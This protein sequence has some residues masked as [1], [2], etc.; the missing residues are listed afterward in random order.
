MIKRVLLL[1][2]G[3]IILWSCQET[4]TSYQASKKRIV[5]TTSILAD[6]VRN[7]VRDSAEVIA[8]MGYGIDPHLFK[9]TPQT[10]TALQEADIIVSNGLNL[11][12]KMTEILQKLT[13]EKKI[14]FASDGLEKSDLISVGPNTF[15]PHIW[16][17]VPLWAEACKYI[18]QEIA[19]VDTQNRDFYEENLFIYIEKLTALHEDI[20]IEIKQIPPSQ[21]ILITVHDAFQYFG[22]TYGIEV[23]SLQGVSTVSDYGVKD[24][25][26]LIQLIVSRKVKAVFLESTISPKLMQSV[27][28]GCLQ[29]KHQVLIGGTLFTDALGSPNSKE[30]TYIGMMESNLQKIVS[31]LK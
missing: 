17:S 2:L 5:C 27:V 18:T 25:E 22:K 16:L 7:I 31:A 29:K 9:P 20:V 23:E 3:G 12:G 30:G 24:V 11:E 1:F 15:D 14:I 10:I 26:N 8:L 21:R 13:S 6:A 28:E 4:E 19:A